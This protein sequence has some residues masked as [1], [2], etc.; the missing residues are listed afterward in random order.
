M[1]DCILF[2][3]RV[4]ALALGALSSEEREEC[5]AHLASNVVHEGCPEAL[6]LAEASAAL[7]GESLPPVAPAPGGWPRIE[8]RLPRRSDAPPPIFGG[9]LGWAIAAV[10]AVAL[11][12]V[13]FK[14]SELAAQLAEGQQRIAL[15][16][17]K[18][19]RL[20]SCLR[21]LASARDQSDR[22][23]QVVALL[24]LPATQIVSLT[25]QA[26]V[27]YR[28]SAVVNG[29][30]KRAAVVG[31]ALAPQT[32]KDFE[33]WLIRGSAKI[34]AGLLRADARGTTIALIEPGLMASGAPDAF[35][36]T[37]E[38]AGGVPQPE[39]PIVLLGTMPKG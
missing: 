16:E 24:Q 37:L 12:W 33:L 1:I 27:P 5:E 23:R 2:K 28:A 35:A 38:R 30:E 11:L 6:A 22:E 31:S 20:D 3:E 39:G 17:A 32:G 9:T 10:A 34:P 19:A 29:A 8:A 4:W 25:P 14:R 36:I 18:G 7:L 21:D 15:L 26:G 13:G